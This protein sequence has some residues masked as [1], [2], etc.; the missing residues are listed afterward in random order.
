MPPSFEK[1]NS[2]VLA[3]FDA[4]ENCAIGET[5]HSAG[6]NT[7]SIVGGTA[8]QDTEGAGPTGTSVAVGVSVGVALFV[9]VGV[10]EGVAVRVGV[11]VIDGVAVCVGDTGGGEVFVAVGGCVGGGQVGV[12]IGGPGG[13]TQGGRVLGGPGGVDIG[14]LGPMGSKGSRGSELR[15]K[16]SFPSV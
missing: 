14:G 9:G 8:A 12:L 6:W 11:Q 7:P 2:T 1:Y 16:T 3:G 10:T 5:G 15:I 13:V 4:A